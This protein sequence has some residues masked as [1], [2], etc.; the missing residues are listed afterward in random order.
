MAP[1]YWPFAPLT[2]AQVAARNAQHAA[3]Y[4]APVVIRPRLP[5]GARQ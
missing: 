4:G 1:L 2:P 3:I 5:Q